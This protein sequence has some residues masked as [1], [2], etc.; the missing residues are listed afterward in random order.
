MRLPLGGGG[1]VG[2]RNL[3]YSLLVGFG[4]VAVVAPLGAAPYRRQ[5]DT[6]SFFRGTG[7]VHILYA[8]RRNRRCCHISRTR[9]E[10]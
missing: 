10:S 1:G 5:V 3:D 9:G 4:I 2:D 7:R 6:G 8:R